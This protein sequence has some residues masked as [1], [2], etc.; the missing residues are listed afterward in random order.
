MRSKTLAAICLMCLSAQW[1]LAQWQPIEGSYYEGSG[2]GDCLFYDAMTDD[3]GLYDGNYWGDQV[4]LFWDI[5]DQEWEEVD[6]IEMSWSL[7]EE[8]FGYGF[9]ETKGNVVFSE[10][11]DRWLNICVIW[12]DGDFS[13]FYLGIWE[14]TQNGWMPVN[15]ITISKLRAEFALA[16]NDAGNIFIV[17]V[18]SSEHETR[19]L[20]G[21]TWKK[22]KTA[23]PK[24]RSEVSMAFDNER[25]QLVLFGGT[26]GREK[27]DGSVKS[28]YLNDTWIFADNNWRKTE[29]EYS[30]SGRSLSYMFYRPELKQVVLYGG[31]SEK[32]RK[33]TEKR[34]RT[35]NSDIWRWDG[36]RWIQMAK[37]TE[38]DGQAIRGPMTYD[39]RRDR[40]IAFYENQLWEYRFSNSN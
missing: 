21:F 10:K 17:G 37:N 12:R 8:R 36:K 39:S 11:L 1:A 31:Y 4:T 24:R 25:K 28:V 19:V 33:N 15:L 7:L 32:P 20:D 40:M 26:R 16:A 30:P 38:V 27:K 29:V 34:K 3:I 23:N 22:F 14:L 18:D 5:G 9:E 13:P 35:Y 6:R 2:W